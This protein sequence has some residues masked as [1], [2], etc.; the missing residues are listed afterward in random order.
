MQ[1]KTWLYHFYYNKARLIFVRRPHFVLFYCGNHIVPPQGGIRTAVIHTTWTAGGHRRRFRGRKLWYHMHTLHYMT[2]DQL[3]CCEGE[4][5]N[6]QNEADLQQPEQELAISVSQCVT[7]QCSFQLTQLQ[8]Y[9]N[10]TKRAAFYDPPLLDRI[11]GSSLT[12]TQLQ[13]ILIK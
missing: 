5:L 1:K 6:Q 9:A 7:D 12:N 10:Q 4:N 11:T 8:H 13:A 2:C 3:R